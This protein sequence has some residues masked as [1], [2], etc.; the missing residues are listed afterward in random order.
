[1]SP[2]GKDGAEPEGA[3]LGP[4]ALLC[5]K[6][7]GSQGCRHSSQGCSSRAQLLQER[8]L[9][10]IF[11]VAFQFGVYLRHRRFTSNSV[12]LE[13]APSLHV[14]NHRAE[15]ETRELLCVRVTMSPTKPHCGCISPCLHCHRPFLRLLSWIPCPMW[16]S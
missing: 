1:M 2:Q 10:L 12:V 5:D 8:G 16:L 11:I 7:Q 4:A 9:G 15:I 14:S 6:E 3:E 13:T